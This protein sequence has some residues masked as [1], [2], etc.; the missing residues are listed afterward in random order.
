MVVI[1]C[2]LSGVLILAYAAVCKWDNRQRDKAGVP[3]GFDHAYEDDLTD[4]TVRWLD[5]ISCPPKGSSLIV[6]CRIH[7]SDISFDKEWDGIWHRTA[8]KVISARLYVVL[9]VR[10]LHQ[11]IF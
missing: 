6:S 11:Y 4:R 9:E 8:I 1:C 10:K 5:S 7:N 2:I 3:E